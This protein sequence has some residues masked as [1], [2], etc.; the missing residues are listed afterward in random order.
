MSNNLHVVATI[1][2]LSIQVPSILPRPPLRGHVI[3]F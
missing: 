2:A 3:I 1:R